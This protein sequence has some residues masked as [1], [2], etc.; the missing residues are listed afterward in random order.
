MID[1]S[2]CDYGTPEMDAFKMR[3]KQDERESRRLLRIVQR[4]GKDTKSEFFSTWQFVDDA[5]LRERQ[6]P[7]NR[8]AQVSVT[9]TPIFPVGEKVVKLRDIITKTLKLADELD[10]YW[11][12]HEEG[13]TLEDKLGVDE[14]GKS[15][16]CDC[17]GVRRDSL[18]SPGFGK[19]NFPNL[20]NDC[21]TRL[22]V[23]ASFDRDIHGS[24][25]SQ[26][27]AVYPLNRFRAQ[28]NQV[29]IAEWTMV[30]TP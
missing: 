26:E 12:V 7:S 13:P 28:V 16:C 30:N 6:K 1:I 2:G 17:C 24:T 27:I 9:K 3:T 19:Y 11:L 4:E 20:C 22:Y 18:A 23:D 10:A 21:A 25:S 14:D 5:F 29:P 15:I 8:K